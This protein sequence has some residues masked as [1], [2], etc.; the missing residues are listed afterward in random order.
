MGNFV[1]RALSFLDNNFGG[2]VP[3]IELTA[4]DWEVVRDVDVILKAFANNMEHV[5]MR[6]ALQNVLAVSRRGNQYMQATQPWVL[7]KDPNTKARAGSVIGLAANLAALLSALLY[8]FMPQ[9]SRQIREQCGLGQPLLLP[10]T[11]AQILPEGHKIG[12]VG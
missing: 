3:A 5:H 1:L 6:E 2:L 8:P 10:E 4:E 7:V 12:K 9:T 11:F